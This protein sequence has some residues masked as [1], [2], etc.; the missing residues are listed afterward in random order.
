MWR[1][2]A[3]STYFADPVDPRSSNSKEVVDDV[4]IYESLVS[5]KVG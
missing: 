2:T 3:K 5:R 4:L 1:H